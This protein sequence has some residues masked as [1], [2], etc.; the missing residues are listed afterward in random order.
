MILSTPVEAKFNL[1]GIRRSARP[2][3]C[4]NPAQFLR[5]F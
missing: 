4:P 3:K 2:A 5:P 1:R